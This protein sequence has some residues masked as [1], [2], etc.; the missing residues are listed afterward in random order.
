[1]LFFTEASIKLGQAKY[2]L[3]RNLSYQL[4]GKDK[5]L[6]DDNTG[7]YSPNTA[8]TGQLS[9]R[10]SLSCDFVFCSFLFSFLLSIVDRHTREGN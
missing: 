4:S 5:R 2:Q 7:F 9:F 10:H 8:T 1:M 6:D 3:D